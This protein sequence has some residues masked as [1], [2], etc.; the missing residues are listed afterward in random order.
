MVLFMKVDLRSLMP[1]SDGFIIDV[2]DG[3]YGKNYQFES[4]CDVHD[5]DLFLYSAPHNDMYYLVKIQNGR[6]K[7]IL[8]EQKGEKLIFPYLC[9]LRK[10]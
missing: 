3:Y 4:V 9:G 6:G 10:K 2:S 5:G 1:F 8:S 7:I